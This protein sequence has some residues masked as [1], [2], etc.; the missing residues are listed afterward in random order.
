MVTVRN[1]CID[2]NLLPYA[3]EY[4]VGGNSELKACPNN[5]IPDLYKSAGGIQGIRLNT[6]GK[7]YRSYSDY[8]NEA[9]GFLWIKD[10]NKPRDITQLSMRDIQI[11]V[12]CKYLKDNKTVGF[13]VKALIDTQRELRTFNVTPEL[14]RYYCELYKVFTAHFSH[15]TGSKVRIMSKDIV[16]NYAVM[17][18]R[19][20]PVQVINTKSL[21]MVG[22]TRKYATP[23]FE[24]LIL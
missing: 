21:E 8:I 23:Y 16:R 7:V 22:Y 12:E 11:F 18:S 9:I 14:M 19:V 13:K 15:G 3:I 6:D 10:N 20:A 24:P 4:S 17:R 5:M 2:T 1:F